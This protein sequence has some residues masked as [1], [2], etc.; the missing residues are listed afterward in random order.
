[1]KGRTVRRGW[2]CPAC[3]RVFANPVANVPGLGRFHNMVCG[4]PMVR[5]E[6]VER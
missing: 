1:M 5:C 3:H 4:A 2:Y 6:V